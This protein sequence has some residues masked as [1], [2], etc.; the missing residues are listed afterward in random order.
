VNNQ[1]L[2]IGKY[3]PFEKNPIKWLL[4]EKR[5]VFTNKNILPQEVNQ[6]YNRAKIVLN[7][8]HETQQ[9]G[10]NPK[11]FESSGAGAYQIC[12]HNPYIAS[13]FPN[14]E[15]G[16]YKNEQE[17]FDLIEDAL[18]NDKSENAKNAQ[19]IILANHTFLH[20][21]KEMLAVLELK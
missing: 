2:I 16:L 8:H 15:V 18:Q 21:V 17:L 5:G 4:R 19:E 20:R 6:L 9:Y 12:D 7:I 14:G 3:K 10:A 11:V 13:L 1:I